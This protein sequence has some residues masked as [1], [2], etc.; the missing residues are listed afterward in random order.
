M[1]KNRHVP[2]LETQRLRLRPIRPTDK[3]ALFKYRSDEQTNRFQGW[4]PK[5][6][7]DVVD[8]IAKNPAHFNKAETWFQLIII[9]K[10]S[11]EIIGDAGIHFMDVENKQ[12]EIGCTLNKHY[13]AKGFA[14]EALSAVVDYLFKTLHKHRIV[15]SIDPEN[16]SS[17]KLVERLG[18]RKEAHFKKSVRLRGKW[19]DDIVYALL[20]DEWAGK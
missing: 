7:A 17:L 6:V 13:H 8:F 16:T 19:V 10:A 1:Q 18:F 3:H 14:T 4:L 12:C 9:E 20:R 15:A 5:S 2:I 11:G